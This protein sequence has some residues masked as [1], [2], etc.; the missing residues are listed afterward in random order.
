MAGNEVGSDARW[1]LR[2]HRF[3]P[4]FLDYLIAR[5]VKKLYE[6]VA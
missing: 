2:M 5:K 6:T 1:M 4:R 3:F